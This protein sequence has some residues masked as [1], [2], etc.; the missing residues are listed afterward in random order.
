MT[1]LRAEY[2]IMDEIK[3]GLQIAWIRENANNIKTC[4]ELFTSDAA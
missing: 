4:T 1:C 2:K 3:Q